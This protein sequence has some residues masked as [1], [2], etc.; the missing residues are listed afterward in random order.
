MRKLVILIAIPGLLLLLA[1]CSSTGSTSTGKVV[2]SAPVGNNL[3]V[4]ISNADGVLKH[5]DQH[6]TVAFKDAS[7][8]PVDVGSASLSF[9]MPTMGTMAAMNDQ[10]TLTTTATPGVYNAKANIEI[11]GEWQVKVAYD[12]AAGKA[13]TSFHITAQ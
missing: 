8:K 12:G 3:T 13:Q 1:A 5:G 9:F 7:G 4:E 11:A 10:A 6:F 2:K